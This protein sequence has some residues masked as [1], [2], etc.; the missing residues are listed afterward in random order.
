M[1]NRLLC[2]AAKENITPPPELIPNLFGLM[3][4]S[5][6]SVH[7][8][9]LVRVIALGAKEKRVLLVSFDLDKAPCPVTFTEALERE[10]GIPRENMLYF[11]IHA[12][13]VPITG[14]RPFE[15]RNDIRTKDASVQEAVKT[16]EAHILRQLLKAAKRAVCAMEPARY[17]FG[18][19]KSY[20]NGNRVYPYKRRETGDVW[21]GQGWRNDESTDRTLFVMR[22]ENLQGEPIA[23][24]VNY[25][26]HN[27]AMFLNDC[28][29]GNMAI[30]SDISGTVS[31]YLES[32]YGDCVAVWSSGAAGDINCILAPTMEYPDP[33]TGEQSSLCLGKLEYTSG[34]LRFLAAIH[35]RD[36][37]DVHEKIL[38]MRET[39]DIAVATDYSRTPALDGAMRSADYAVKAEETYSIR[40]RLVRIGEIALIGVDGELFSSL[41]AVMKEASPLEHTVLITHESSLLPDNPGYIFDDAAILAIQ[42]VGDGGLPGWMGFRGVPHTIAP[43][44]REST[45]KLFADQT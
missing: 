25:P 35:Y 6:S 39:A 32:A 17:G 7:D 3:C 21:L 14:F 4:S 23:F 31:K 2:G 29:D 16:Y 26:M 8:E 5:F 1:E 34:I 28:G 44:L 15:K 9:L 22:F 45:K 18:Y 11:G 36:I 27:V 10:T 40:L 37:L 41:G 30:S 19:G 43:A 33:A 20:I 38:D 24:F 42:A 13:A 12:H